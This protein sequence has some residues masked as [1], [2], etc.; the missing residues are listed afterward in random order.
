MRRYLLGLLPQGA[1]LSSA[2]C[3]TSPQLLGAGRSSLVRQP[4]GVGQQC[5][6]SHLTGISNLSQ[7]H[8]Y[9]RSA[10]ARCVL[11]CTFRRARSTNHIVRIVNLKPLIRYN[12]AVHLITERR[13]Y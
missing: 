8:I 13:T 4:C 1:R 6:G 5:A 7:T 9:I 10:A 11:P 2:V 12:F 3:W